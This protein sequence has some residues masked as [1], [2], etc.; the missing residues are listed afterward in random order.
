[1]SSSPPSSGSGAVTPD[2]PAPD[3]SAPAAD[4]SAVSA[5]GGGAEE[6]GGCGCS[7]ST[8]GSHRRTEW[9]FLFAAGALRFLAPVVDEDA[10][11]EGWITQRG[12]SIVFADAEVRG[13]SG[14]LAATATLVYKV[15]SRPLEI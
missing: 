2:A 1:M 13:A 12:R 4:A 10:V 5:D 6:E 11:A 7:A 8:G 3:A 15:S 14:T 9:I